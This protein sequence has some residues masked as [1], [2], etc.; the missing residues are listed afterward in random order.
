TDYG[1]SNIPDPAHILDGIIKGCTNMGIFAGDVIDYAA[2]AFY[3]GMSH[4]PGINKLMPEHVKEFTNRK[5][6]EGN[7]AIGDF[8]G[9]GTP[10]DWLELVGFI[11]NTPVYVVVSGVTALV[12]QEPMR[13]PTIL[14][15]LGDGIKEE[16]TH[17]YEERGYVNGSLYVV[18][19]LLPLLLGT[20][21]LGATTKT[22]EETAQAAKILKEAET[23]FAAT[24]LKETEA[25]VKATEAVEAA[26]LL[27]MRNLLED[28]TVW[29]NQPVLVTQE[30]V[31]IGR[32][33]TFAEI[34]A[35]QTE[36]RAARLRPLKLTKKEV[37]DLGWLPGRYTAVEIEGTVKV[38]GQELDV[39]RRVY[40]IEIDKTYMP[41][42]PKAEGLS[43]YELMSKGRS[44]YVI[45]SS[46][47][48][49]IVELHHLTQNEPC[50]MIEMAETVHGKHSNI[51]HGLVEDGSSFRN[52]PNL[53]KQYN[54]FRNN[55]WK[56]RALED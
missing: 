53:E 39:S 49:S 42:D 35:Q 46:G 20:K 26:K 55:Y 12:T 40:Q 10:L 31:P 8:I 25:A 48:E 1:K 24:T 22:A 7:A 29:K 3:V 9:M 54:N 45:D 19:E 51:L 43:N 2:S 36:L 56:L 30:G 13:F 33:F 11:M 34:R 16:I 32:Q 23:A 41:L 47:K 6:A 52:A 21:G 37:V 15:K 27:E 38:G 4:I 28:M 44:P 18:G 50:G 5:F 14:E 17:I